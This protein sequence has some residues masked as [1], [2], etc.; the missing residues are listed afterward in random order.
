MGKSQ[1]ER[2]PPPA[3]GRR[4]VWAIGGLVIVVAGAVA[5][6][7]LM[8]WY[9]MNWYWYV[10]EPE[11]LVRQFAEYR[12]AGDQRAD[13]LLG[14]PPVVPARAVSREKA[15]RLDAEFI[16][17]QPLR[18]D[19]VRPRPPEPGQDWS[20]PRFKLVAKGSAAS[21]RML[22]EGDSSPSQR[23]LY[24]PD[25]IVEVRDGRIYGVRAQ[26]HED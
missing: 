22:V 15:A 10:R 6:M 21:E 11:A 17:R 1:T 19:A 2:P 24:N 14:P 20:V 16:L 5:G 13:A 12:N 7:F 18:I 26:L 8:N 9:L 3:A 4:I 25:I 23:T